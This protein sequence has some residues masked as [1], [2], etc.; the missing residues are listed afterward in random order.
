VPPHVR[1][2]P[3]PLSH[4]DHR[5]PREPRGEQVVDTPL[6]RIVERGGRLGE[7]DPRGLVQQNAREREPRC[8]LAE[9]F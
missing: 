8:S 5:R 9:S 1:L 4:A 2:G 3:G 7:Q 6:D